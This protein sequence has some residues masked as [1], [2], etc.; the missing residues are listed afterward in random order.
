[1]EASVAVP[2]KAVVN[3]KKQR[4]LGGEKKIFHFHLLE[5]YLSVVINH[6]ELWSGCSRCY[7]LLWQLLHAKTQKTRSC[8]QKL[9][10]NKEDKAFGRPTDTW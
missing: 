10:G 2:Y 1:M 4:C 3:L 8:R 6:E 9:P 5:V 7:T